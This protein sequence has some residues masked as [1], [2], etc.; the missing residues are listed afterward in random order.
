MPVTS[1]TPSEPE[2]RPLVIGIGNEHRHDDR[3]GLDVVRGLLG[4][5]KGLARIAECTGDVTTLLDLWK[6]EREVIVVDAVRSGH[7]PGTVL[8]LDDALTELPRLG[9]TSTHGLSLTEAIGLGRALGKFPGHLVVYGIEAEDVEMGEGLS[10]R[11]SSG[12]RETI[13]LVATEV[14]SL[15]DPESYEESVD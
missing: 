3:C 8:R 9:A 4:R 14:R 2:R 6:S 7:R 10:E 1:K 5:L 13:D 15:L 11:V 12:V